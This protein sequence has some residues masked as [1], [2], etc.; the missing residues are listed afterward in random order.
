MRFACPACSKAYRIPRGVIGEGGQATIRCPA[1][2]VSV[3]VALGR[4]GR[5]RYGA[6]LASDGGTEIAEA[7]KRAAADGAASEPRRPTAELEV[8][9]P[10][11]PRATAA[12]R[13]QGDTGEVEA[14]GE[15]RI[16][17]VVIAGESCGPFSQTQVAEQIAHGRVVRETPVWRRGQGGWK[18][19][20]EVAE[21]AALLPRSAMRPRRAAAR[22]STGFSYADQVG[23]IPSPDLELL[24]AR[25][26]TPAVT[27]TAPALGDPRRRP[28]AEGDAE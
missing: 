24:S 5:L 9:Q 19:L 13:T 8:L 22:A 20:Q 28:E 15:R 14:E 18:R 11:F 7:A 27:R 21:L 1:C 4:D 2:G 17:H 25:G 23:G 10:L 3:R 26:A 6:R 16:W 12:A